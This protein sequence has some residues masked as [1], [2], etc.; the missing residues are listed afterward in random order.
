MH[1]W[2]VAP[3]IH[4]QHETPNFELTKIRTQQTRTVWPTQVDR[5]RRN[6]ASKRT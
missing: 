1:Q 4:K 3:D 5:T 2:G 6:N